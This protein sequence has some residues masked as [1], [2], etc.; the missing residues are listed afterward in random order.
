VAPEKITGL[1]SPEQV[2]HFWIEAL[3][4]S[5]LWG[6]DMFVHVF[7][8][9][10]IKSAGICQNRETVWQS[11]HKNKKFYPNRMKL[12]MYHMPNVC[13]RHIPH[14]T[15]GGTYGFIANRFNDKNKVNKVI[16]HDV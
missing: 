1:V 13:C 15:C 12:F 4:E 11:R 8:L 16:Q 6:Y 3:S 2:G 10:E 5:I 7:Y 14:V 9:V